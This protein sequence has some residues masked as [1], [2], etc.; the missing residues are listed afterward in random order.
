MT[1]L[2]EKRGFFPRGRLM[3]A[4]DQTSSLTVWHEALASCLGGLHWILSLFIIIGYYY[5]WWWWRLMILA[6]LNWDSL[7]NHT[8]AVSPKHCGPTCHQKVQKLVHHWVPLAQEKLAFRSWT[9]FS[10]SS[11]HS[12]QAVCGHL[13]L[14]EQTWVHASVSRDGEGEI[15]NPG[16]IPDRAS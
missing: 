8:R 5:L 10:S 9:N 3:M 15:M 7:G 6:P 12:L 13:S 14:P 16:V 4:Q 11:Y 2:Y 1:H